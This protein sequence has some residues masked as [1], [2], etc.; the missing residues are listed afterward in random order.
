GESGELLA[1]VGEALIAPDGQQ[2]LPFDQAAPEAPA[3][4]GAATVEL[5]PEFVDAPA[6]VR[7]AAAVQEVS[8]PAQDD[9]ETLLERA[10]WLEEEER[11]DEAAAVC[12]RAIVADPRRAEAYFNLGNILRMMDR[13]RAAEE[14]YRM[15]V[16][17]EPTNSLALYNLA[18]ILEEFEEYGEAIEALGEAVRLDPTFADAHFNLATC[19]EQAGRR[20][21]AAV[22]WRAYLRLDPSSEWAR[23]ARRR[24]TG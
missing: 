12:R 1:Q 6:P 11:Y 20:A 4:H 21:D 9:P 3:A 14:M 22:H 7:F 16:A 10:V 5:K 2:M 23:V 15:A 24:L 17:L 13:A 18:D 19:L 8:A